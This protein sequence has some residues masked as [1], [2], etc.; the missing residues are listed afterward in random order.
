MTQSYMSS[1]W[2]IIPPFQST[3]Q[4]VLGGVTWTPIRWTPPPLQN[5]QKASEK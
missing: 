1:I 4:I 2:T 5:I 3:L